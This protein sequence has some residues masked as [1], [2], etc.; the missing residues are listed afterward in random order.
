M[1]AVIYTSTSCH[2]CIKAKILL[3]NREIKFHEFILSSGTNE[4]EL[5]ENQTYVQLSQL[6]DLIPNVKTVPQIWL[7]G[8]Y[9][10]GYN[11]LHEF[12]TSS[13]IESV[14]YHASEEHVAFR[15]RDVKENVG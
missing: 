6:L 14:N 3:K 7:N 10:G 4:S 13:Q 1:E 9:I 11:E 5:A 8:N 2:F 15:A 12:F